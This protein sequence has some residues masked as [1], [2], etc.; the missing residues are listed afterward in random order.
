[1]DAN[2]LCKR[3]GHSDRST[4]YWTSGGMKIGVR[5]GNR[6]RSRESA[7]LP[8]LDCEINRREQLGGKHRGIEPGIQVRFCLAGRFSLPLY[9]KPPLFQIP[10]VGPGQGERFFEREYRSVFCLRV[11]KLEQAER[12]NQYARRC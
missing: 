8:C 10:I 7:E 3:L 2:Q 12:S 1:M 6:P 9:I 11:C 4:R 5:S